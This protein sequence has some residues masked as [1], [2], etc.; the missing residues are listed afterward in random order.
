MTRAMMLVLAMLVEFLPAPIPRTNVSRIPQPVRT[1]ATA[2]E[3]G[4]V[5]EKAIL[6]DHV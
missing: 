1:L 4:A 2:R 5:W 6:S 3:A